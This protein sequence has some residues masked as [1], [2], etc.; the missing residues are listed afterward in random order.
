MIKLHAYAKLNLSLDIKGKRADGYHELDSIMQ[1]ISLYDTV[2]I[3]KADTVCV[4]MDASG[5]EAQNN[6]ALAAAQ[7]FMEKTGIAGAHISIEK[8]IP[9]QAGLGGASAD[10]AAVLIGLDSLY[11]TNL[12]KET[13]AALGKRIGA[14][15][16][17]ALT[18]GTARV[19]GIGENISPLFPSAFMHYAVVKPYAGVPTREAYRRYKKSV[20]LRMGSVE[21]A[22]LKGDVDLFL[23]FAGNALGIPA[24]AISPEILRAADALLAAGALRA[25]MSGSG[26]CMFAPFSSWKE[27]QSAAE[28]V[29]GNFELC[30]ALSPC[31]QG[32]KIVENGGSP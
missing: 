9:M 8:R 22:V 14:D 28:R 1:S 31:G 32:V 21:Y 23:R 24:L 15:V 19:R 13:L 27:A 2:V 16:P 7:A 11:E 6:S 3:R 18:G 4:A 17:F 29:K 30:M 10:A 25:L 26:S 12:S 20:P 5:I